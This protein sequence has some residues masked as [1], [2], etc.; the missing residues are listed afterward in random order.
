LARLGREEARTVGGS[1]KWSL[2]TAHQAERR[3]SRKN[4]D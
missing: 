4:E 1:I 2:D 3:L